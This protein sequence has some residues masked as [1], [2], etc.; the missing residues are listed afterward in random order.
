MPGYEGAWPSN[1]PDGSGIEKVWAWI[2]TQL[3]YVPKSAKDTNEKL[4]NVV[5]A[6]WE[7]ID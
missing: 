6:I 2:K 5:V 3:R 1:S 7:G 4:A